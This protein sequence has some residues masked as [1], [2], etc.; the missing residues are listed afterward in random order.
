MRGAGTAGAGGL[1]EGGQF[2]EGDICKTQ[3]ELKHKVM[4]GGRTRGAPP[5]PGV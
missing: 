4:K 3:E 1:A 5:A 2:I